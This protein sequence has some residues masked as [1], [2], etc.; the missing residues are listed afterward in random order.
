MVF[1]QSVVCFFAFYGIIQMGINIYE[2]L[3][4]STYK[5]NDNV[6]IIITVKN[7][8]N[9]IEGIIRS[10]LW[11]SLNNSHGG[12][13][14]NILVVDMGSTDETPDILKRLHIEYNFIEVTD[15]KSYAKILEKIINSVE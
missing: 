11:K 4:N 9:S 6:H 7:Q 10:V 14:P 12:I 3:H 15:S 8:Q 5:R 2:W 1:L 13:V